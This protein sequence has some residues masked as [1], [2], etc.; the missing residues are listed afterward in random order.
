MINN[1]SGHID[2]PVDGSASITGRIW[3]PVITNKAH[4]NFLG[5]THGSNN[6]GELTAIGEVLRWSRDKLADGL[7]LL[8]RYDSKY[9]CMT[10]QN[11]W[12]TSS[13][14]KLAAET[15]APALKAR[16]D[17]AEATGHPPASSQPVPAA[18][19]ALRALSLLLTG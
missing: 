9:A 15:S 6:T 1:A 7:T 5:A 2:S 17:T 18:S 19:S 14:I 16:L 10:T 4:V 3:G 8:V 12:A 11:L 13:N